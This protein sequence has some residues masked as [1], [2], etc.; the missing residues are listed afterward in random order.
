MTLPINKWD[1]YVLPAWGIH[2]AML[3]VFNSNDRNRCTQAL[4]NLLSLEYSN[5]SY[6]SSGNPDNWTKLVQSGMLTGQSIIPMS[7]AM[8]LDINKEIN[9]L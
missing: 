7:Q 9:N 8:N 6:I 3:L 4:R 1:Y 2:S 5:I